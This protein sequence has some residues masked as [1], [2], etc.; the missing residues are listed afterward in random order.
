MDI[1]K[2]MRKL[3]LIVFLLSIF[4]F[5]WLSGCCPIFS[6]FEASEIPTSTSTLTSRPTRTSTNT[7]TP[8]ET[9]LP[10]STPTPTF[11]PTPPLLVLENTPLGESL[12]P[13]TLENAPQVSGL[14]EWYES[15]VSDLEWLPDGSMLAVANASTINLYD[16]NT[17]EILRTL[18][19]QREGIVDIAISPN[20]LW[21][22]SGMVRG[23]E[24]TG[25][26]TS[27]ELW[28]GPDWKPLGVLFGLNYGLTDMIFSPDGETLT[29]AYA[30]PVS[31]DNRVDFWSAITWNTT[32]SLKIGPAL[33][34][35]FSP[36]SN[37]LAT[38]PNRYAI[39]IWDI[40]EQ[41]FAF[42]FKTSFTGAVNT[43]AFSPDGVTLASGHYDGEIYYWDLRTG[44]PV[45][46]SKTE[47]VIQSLA[48]SPDGRILATGGSFQNSLVRLWSA[49][50]GT[51]LRT[52]EGHSSGVSNLAFSPDS[53][54]LVSASYDGTIR[55]WGLRPY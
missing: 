5:S 37:L 17:R 4:T 7:P 45:L 53:Q 25:Y 11:T 51:L 26:S 30:S 38:S 18:Y 40:K 6:M 16:I 39:R 19:P 15:S 42:E 49:G 13:I 2:V 28:Q 52:L 21:L 50:T 22:V 8:T 31:R 43:L 55:L 29:T 3:F 23:S 20:G 41:K 24:K 32:G 47:E 33:N 48:Y 1:S 54:Y 27:I 12:P 35:A 10:T 46:T 44:V 34:L 14:A 36:D 9:S